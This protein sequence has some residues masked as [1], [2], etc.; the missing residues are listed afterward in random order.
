MTNSPI[1]YFSTNQAIFGSRDLEERIRSGSVET[2]D[3]A[4]AIITGQTPDGGLFIPDRFPQIDV[5]EIEIMKGQDYHQIF[6]RV[7]EPFF[8]GLL[9]REEIN[10]IGKE[11]YSG[12]NGFS[13][14]LE[15]I[16]H[17]Q[18][19]LA[20]LDA[21]PTWA[22]KD[23]AAQV[24]F[25]FVERIMKKAPDMEGEFWDGLK[26][27]DM[28][29]FVTATSGDTGGAMGHAV[30]NR[31]NMM[32]AILYSSRI[33]EEISEI[34]AKQMDTIGDNVVTIRVDGT[35]DDCQ[36]LAK[37]LQADPDLQY[38]NLNS[39]NSISIGRLLPQIAYYFDT[40]SKVADFA[41][42]EIVFTV[43]SGN[44][45]NLVAG[46]YAK[47][48][49]LNAKFNVALNEND[50]FARFYETG[51]Y[52]PASESKPSL[53]NSMNV[54]HP[55]NMRR[56]FQLYGGQLVE[57]TDDDGNIT[58]KVIKQPDMKKLKEDI[59][60]VYSISDEDT[61]QTIKDFYEEGHEIEI[62]GEYVTSAIEPHGSVALAATKRLRQE[63]YLGKVITFQTAHLYKFPE[64]LNDLGIKIIKTSRMNELEQ[65]P[66]GNHISVGNDYSK[67][68]GL[69]QEFHALQL[70]K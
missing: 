46:L 67:V 55:S 29:T 40:Y 38:M 35:F 59:I 14:F 12:V 62:N 21:G 20:R 1:R 42:E 17:G 61:V 45:G 15:N 3:L 10:E 4:E 47:K 26:N 13:P 27:I 56:L 19:W 32:M 54:N 23:Y 30:H 70:K 37:K 34:Q 24:L 25:R 36:T 41:G 6:S 43:P 33:G 48:M 57:E 9:S 68:K 53:S 49:G 39:A 31:D 44:F 60:G 18:D 7:M 64:V 50:V 63:G 8:D 22:F 11:A 5:S 65:G 2:V 51:I 58:V 66:M 52:E 28:M 16:A 69:L